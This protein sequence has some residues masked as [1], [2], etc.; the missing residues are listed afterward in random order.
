MRIGQGC[1]VNLLYLTHSPLP[2]IPP[3][4]ISFESSPNIRLTEVFLERTGKYSLNVGNCSLIATLGVGVARTLRPYWYSMHRRS[5][6]QAKKGFHTRLYFLLVFSFSTPC[7]I[8]ITFLNSLGGV[9]RTVFT[10]N[11]YLKTCFA[12]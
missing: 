9:W 10:N 12:N 3:A 7:F 2:R 4:Y 1:L 11:R 6:A 8:L 5:D